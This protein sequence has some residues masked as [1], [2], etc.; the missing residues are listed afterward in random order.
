MLIY[1]NT[2]VPLFIY[3]LHYLYALLL[4]IAHPYICLHRVFHT[5]GTLRSSFS[6]FE[7]P[8]DINNVE[9]LS[10]TVAGLEIRS[11][12]YGR[13]SNTKANTKFNVVS[14]NLKINT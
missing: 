6:D 8:Q 13:I 9:C 12:V 2:M 14:L 1:Q 10:Y 11:V 4:C 5:S 7:I 3:L